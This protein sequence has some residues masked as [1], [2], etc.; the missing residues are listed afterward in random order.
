MKR[1]VALFLVFVLCQICCGTILTR[2]FLLSLIEDKFDSIV[3]SSIN[4]TR[5]ASD[6]HRLA[7]DLSD[8]KLWAMKMVDANGKLNAGVLK[9]N[10]HQLGSYDECL[11]VRVEK[12]GDLISGQYCSVYLEPKDKRNEHYSGIEPLVKE[13]NLSE[14]KNL[15]AFFQSLTPMVGICA[16]KSC[17][18]AHLSSLWNYTEKFL[19][20]PLHA[21]FREEYCSYKDKPMLPNKI[22]FYIFIFFAASLAVVILSTSYDVYLQLVRKTIKEDIFAIFSLYTNSK[23]LLSTSSSGNLTCLFGIRVISTCWVILGH[24]MCFKS[25]ASNTNTLDIISEWRFHLG[26][27]F[28]LG[29]HYAVDTF[30]TI[31]GLLVL[32]SHSSGENKN[33]CLALYIRRFFRLSPSLF[34]TILLNISVLKHLASGPLWP[35]FA[36]EFSGNCQ[37]NWWATLL[38]VN[39]FLVDEKQCIGPSWFLAVDFQLHL[40]SPLILFVSKKYPNKIFTLVATACSISFIYSFTVTLM[41]RLEFV[42]SFDATQEFYQY[43]YYSTVSRMPSWLIGVFF[44]HLLCC[45]N[46]Q[47]NQMSKTL[48]FLAWSLSLSVMLGLILYHKIFMTN[49]YSVIRSAFFNTFSR[50]IWSLSTG[51]IIFLCS[52]GHGGFINTFLSHP[53]FVV[54]GKLTYSMFLLNCSVIYV[55]VGNQKQPGYFSSFQLLYE[56]CGIFAIVV[57]CSVAMNLIFERPFLSL[58]NHLQRDTNGNL[59]TA[60]VSKKM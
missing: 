29:F 4:G 11:D 40:L 58:I 9:G 16:P 8:Y 46:S 17:S 28:L 45:R 18:V 47:K 41:K 2:P 14:T 1:T 23:S 50:T 52:T 13:W 53:I 32:Y 7:T 35:E 59:Q 42:V 37:E 15:R 56:F 60:K 39:N 27:T 33:S 51:L 3:D 36:L 19:D 21:T 6:L 43:L 54:L 25:I 48:S 30:F 22:D 24:F 34:A 57:V 31:S 10:I 26:N 5:C 20:V 55:V 49:D 44:G 12:K 38:F